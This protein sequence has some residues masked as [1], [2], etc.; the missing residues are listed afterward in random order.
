MPWWHSKDEGN[1]NTES[2]K[3]VDLSWFSPLYFFSEATYEFI[4]PSVT[5]SHCQYFFIMP[6]ISF[7][8]SMLNLIVFD[9]FQSVSHGRNHTMVYN[10]T[11]PLSTFSLFLYN[12][13][14][15]CL[16]FCTSFTYTVFTQKVVFLNQIMIVVLS[17]RLFFIVFLP[18]FLVVRL[19]ACLSVSFLSFVSCFAPIDKLSLLQLSSI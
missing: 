10:L 4:Y 8:V 13:E 15:I 2:Y 19:A 18:S 1:I 5:L 6:F 14:Y 3:R 12:T 7:N 16:C 11:I 17:G 9:M